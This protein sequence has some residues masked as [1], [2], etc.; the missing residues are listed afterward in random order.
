MVRHVK[1]PVSAVHR[2]VSNVP[3]LRSLKFPFSYTTLRCW[4]HA[5]SRYQ[6]ELWSEVGVYG[7]HYV[8]ESW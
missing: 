3:I 6:H 5:R 2:L 7:V 8:L 4:N 1:E